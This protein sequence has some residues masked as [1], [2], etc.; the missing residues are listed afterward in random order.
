MGGSDVQPAKKSNLTVI[1]DLTM[2]SSRSEEIMAIELLERNDSFGWHVQEINGHD[3]N[4]ISKSL[5]FA[6]QEVNKPSAI[7]AHNTKVRSIFME[8]NNN[9]NTNSKSRRI[10]SSHN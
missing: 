3:F 7:V 1:I 8:D 5:S 9:W 10:E 2:V 4:E 6:R